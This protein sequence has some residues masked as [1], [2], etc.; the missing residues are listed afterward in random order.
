MGDFLNEIALIFVLCLICGFGLFI[1]ICI[2]RIFCDCRPRR[3]M[4]E[5]Q[6]LIV[7]MPPPLLEAPITVTNTNIK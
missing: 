7:H 6:Q 2:G 4:E 1:F 5:L 3:N